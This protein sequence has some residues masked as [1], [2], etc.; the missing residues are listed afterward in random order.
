MT[1]TTTTQEN[2]IKLQ[3]PPVTSIPKVNVNTK[4]PTNITADLRDMIR[5][6]NAW[7][8]QLYDWAR[9][10][11]LNDTIPAQ[12]YDRLTLSNFHPTDSWL[13]E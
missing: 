8:V 4:R 3:P 10:T 1:T 12:I 13:A 11:F 2:I 7:D 5:A 9:D 6:A